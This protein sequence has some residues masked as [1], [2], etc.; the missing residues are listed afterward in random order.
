MIARIDEAAKKLNSMDGAIED[1]STSEIERIIVG[2]ASDLED[3]A[4]DCKALSV[5]IEEAEGLLQNINY[6]L[7]R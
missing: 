6:E 1:M 5:K 4:I 7:I 2:V 3:I